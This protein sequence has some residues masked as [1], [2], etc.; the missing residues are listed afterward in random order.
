M[1][2][3]STPVQ[4]M[5][6][7]IQLITADQK[8]GSLPHLN[9]LREIWETAK[10]S[11]GVFRGPPASEAHWTQCEAANW[12]FAIQVLRDGAA[13]HCHLFSPESLGRFEVDSNCQP[14]YVE[15]PE[16]YF[17]GLWACGKS[18]REIGIAV[19]AWMDAMETGLVI[20]PPAISP[21]TD[22]LLHHLTDGQ[23]SRWY[24][25]HARQKTQQDMLAI[26]Q[27]AQRPLRATRQDVRAVGPR[28]RET[29]Q[30]SR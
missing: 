17:K 5:P 6:V 19:L 8:V 13:I 24:L 21:T 23:Y 20:D 12:Y 28:V 14:V 26:T 15:N 7:T 22:A 9:Q 30:G 25:D 3:L 11:G 18:L 27:E 10:Y 29:M 4:T 1:T 16:G 2:A